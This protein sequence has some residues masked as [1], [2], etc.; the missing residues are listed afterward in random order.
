MQK[1]RYF[2]LT[3]DA[4][5]SSRFKTFYKILF[6]TFFTSR[7]MCQTLRKKDML[8]GRWNLYYYGDFFYK[9]T[10]K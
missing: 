4:R 6:S 2:A 8:Q 5:F 9:I 7:L 10:V 3:D 1:V